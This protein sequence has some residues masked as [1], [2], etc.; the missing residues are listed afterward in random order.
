MGPLLR[1]INEAFRKFND[2]FNDWPIWILSVTI[3]VGCVIGLV[4]TKK[5]TGKIKL[6]DLWPTLFFSTGFLFLVLNSANIEI[7][8]YISLMKGE[9]GVF[10]KENWWQRK[11]NSELKLLI[12]LGANVSTARG[13]QYG[14]S[15]L[16][17]AAQFGN[18]EIIQLMI[19]NGAQL[20]TRDNHSGE[21]PIHW[22]AG[23]GP[24]ENMKFLIDAGADV[25]AR[26]FND[27]N[28]LHHAAFKGTSEK[29]LMLLEFGA[30]VNL[31]NSIGNNAWAYAQEN[32][33]L[34]ETEG[35]YA[36]KEATLDQTSP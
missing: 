35:F 8:P 18:P 9:C 31:K 22:V 3:L 1:S 2:N 28:P 10:C 6:S 21:M 17:W 11:T 12:R 14:E 25:N 32:Y 7:K 20:G 15:P 27:N 34:S 26:D 5:N 13:E 33:A 36:L 24:I 16:H 19:A 30:E 23:Y 4:F 29:I